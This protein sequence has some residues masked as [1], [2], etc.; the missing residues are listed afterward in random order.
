ML[1][2]FRHHRLFLCPWVAVLP[3]LSVAWLCTQTGKLYSNREARE[4]SQPVMK[5]R[6]KPEETWKATGRSPHL[7]DLSSRG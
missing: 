3:H 4:I 1:P 7:S 2:F 6:E 5:L